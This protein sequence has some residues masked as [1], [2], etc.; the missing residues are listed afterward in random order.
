MSTDLKSMTIDR[1][2]ID[3]SSQQR[4][5]QET[6]NLEAEQQ[7]GFSRFRPTIMVLPLPAILVGYAFLS[8][9]YVFQSDFILSIPVKYPSK[10]T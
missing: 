6:S 9:L 3:E 7:K 10:E 2:R 4:L 8:V 5:N 1:A